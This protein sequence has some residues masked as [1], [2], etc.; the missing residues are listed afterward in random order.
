VL[1]VV[2]TS[3]AAAMAVIANFPL[4]K[5]ISPESA[6]CRSSQPP[7]SVVSWRASTARAKMVRRAD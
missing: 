3:V 4:R 1:G 2:S 7:S 5:A 6:R